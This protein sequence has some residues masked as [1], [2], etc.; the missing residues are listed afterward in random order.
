MCNDHQPWIRE[1]HLLSLPLNPNP[2]LN[3]SCQTQSQYFETAIIITFQR[4]GSRN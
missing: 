4:E 3:L 1:K 2:K